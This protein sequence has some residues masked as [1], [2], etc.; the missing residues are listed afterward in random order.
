MFIET[1]RKMTAENK[2][3]KPTKQDIVYSIALVAIVILTA[4]MEGGLC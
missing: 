1:I 4:I 2:K 3:Y